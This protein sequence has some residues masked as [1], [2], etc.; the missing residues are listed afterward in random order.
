MALSALARLEASLGEL[1]GSEVSFERPKDAA[2]G[3]YATNIAL[4]AARRADRAPRQIAE[5]LAGRALS[6]PEIEGAEV[7]GPGFL[8]LRVTD[9]FLGQVLGE[10]DSGYGGGWARSPEKV[11][12][13]M[14]SA[15]P[16]GPITVASARNGALGD[17]VARL[18]EFAGHRVEREYYYNDAGA[19][20]DRFRA[21][22]D[23]VRAGEDVPEDGYHG[24][25]IAGLAADP[26]DPVPEMLERI[27][28]TL[29]R[30]RI[31][32]DS[33]AKQSEL[34]RGLDELLAGLPT[35]KHDGAL[36]V[37]STDFGD[38]KDRVLVRSAEK[39][40]LPTYE[41]ADVAY[42]RS[43][44]DRGFDRAIY[45]LGAD[46]HGVAI[47]FEVVARMLGYDPGRVEV[48][49]Y[50]LVHLTRGGEQAKM[51]KRRG[52]VVFLD[53]FIDEAGVD[54]AR[55]FLVDR[56]HDQSI[57]ID[58]DLAAEKSRK[59]PVYYVQYVHARINGIFREAPE[60]A[61]L[62]AVPRM[63]LAPEERELVKRL[64]E[65]PGVVREAT[66]RRGPHAIPVYAIR[67]ADDFH[68]FY[69]EHVVLESKGGDHQPFR[70]ALIA[71]TRDVVA[72]CL[73]LV[74]V[75]APE[76]M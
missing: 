71:A 32:F 45:V 53:E 21:S 30:F 36:F 54:F 57:E 26:G 56:G 48:L 31:H 29:E 74:G 65:F 40:G 19:Q 11:Q 14:V 58:V 51:S 9:A 5:E 25:Y 8:N 76:R 7:A 39:G 70:L 16:T 50:Q 75:S 67:V 49:L 68:R 2:H 43:K 62:D 6:L 34:E 38:D 60:G 37:R 1:A 24:A 27:E 55:W 20:M 15:N 41:A 47:W 73:D 44:L 22:V 35:Y 66:E 59:N 12:V 33:W 13:E 72:R 63:P 28:S 52:D 4:Q 61:E 42:L 23:A 69:H 18:L 3:D 64:A 10:I 46:H 17:S